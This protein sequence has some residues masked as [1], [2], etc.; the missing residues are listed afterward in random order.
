ML[1]E[2]P[3]ALATG[4]ISLALMIPECN[5]LLEQPD[6]LPGAAL[7]VG[8]VIGAIG[9]YLGSATARTYQKAVGRTIRLTGWG[10]LALA[11]SFGTAYFGLRAPEHWQKVL[12]LAAGCLPLLAYI[13]AV[14]RGLRNP[15][16]TGDSL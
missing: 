7:I 8:A 9:I 11:M 13:G 4:G 2:R 3:I 14:F 6:K 10:L 16:K 1:I 12:F 5:A 15:F